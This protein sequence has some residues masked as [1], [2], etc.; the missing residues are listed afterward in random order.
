MAQE[1]FWNI[2]FHPAIP[3]FYKLKFTAHPARDLPTSASTCSGRQ[4]QRCSH[5]CYYFYYA[6]ALDGLRTPEKVIGSHHPKSV[7]G[8][9]VQIA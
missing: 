2:P 4:P 9:N 7:I 8:Y 1:N 3:E 6:D 5:R